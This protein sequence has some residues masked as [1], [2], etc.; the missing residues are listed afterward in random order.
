MHPTAPLSSSLTVDSAPA[1]PP[2]IAITALDLMYDGFYAFFLLKNGSAPQDNANFQQRTIDFLEAFA[3]Q[4]KQLGIAADDIDAARYAYCAALDEII[5][6]STFSIREEWERKP[7]QLV[8]FGDQLAGEHFFE[9]LE[10]LRARGVAHVQSLEVFHMCLLLG[11]QGRYI[12]DGAEKLHYLKARL[13]DE[14]A[15][16]KGKRGG[17]APHAARPDHIVHKL[18]GDL[19]LWVLAALF[20]LICALGY[21]GL[22]LA[23]DQ[24]TEQ[25]MAAYNQVVKVALRVASLTITLP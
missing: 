10:A 22:R 7:L 15:A 9:R 13:G 6:R 21:L 8:L 4:A 1:A 23:L 12:L 14:I 19:P 5:L 16:M 17:F 18:R 11:F 20:T 2:A 3:R 25:Q 24:H